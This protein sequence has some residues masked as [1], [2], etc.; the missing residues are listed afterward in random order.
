MLRKM[1][2]PKILKFLLG[3]G[4]AA[5]LNLVLIYLII[6][7]LG[8]NTA[9]LR[10]I[11]NVVSIELSLIFSFFVYRTWVWTGGIWNLREV[12]L[13][14]LPL[15]HVSAGAAVITRIFLIFPILDW[16]KVNYGIN[17]IIGAL[18]SASIN[19][20]ISDRFVFK[21]PKQKKSLTYY[22]EALAPA[23][24]ENSSLIGNEARAMETLKSIK[25]LSIVIPAYNEEDCI[26]QTVR[27][28]STVLEQ[29]TIDYEIL[30]VNDNSK[31]NTEQ[32]LQQ[33]NS[34]NSKL[35]YINNYYPNGFGF[36]VRCGLE[37]FTKDAVAVVM[38]DSSDAPE[39]I[40][41]YYHKLQEGYDCVFG[42][43]FIR[44]GKVIDYPTHKLI[45]N[46]LA[47]LFI[48]ILFGL[49]FNDTTNAFKIYRK[50]VIEGISP[51]VSHHFNLTVEMP[52]KAIV[53]GYSYTTIP[54]TW[55]N[56]TTGV[57]KL[58]LKE[59]GSRYLFIVLFIWLE[60]H[61][62]RGDYHLSKNKLLANQRLKSNG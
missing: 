43:R 16:L 26:V 35:R 29:E 41:S 54:I 18:V 34:E 60:K 19:Y 13:R 12:F 31:D 56:R 46:R 22:P 38:A 40:I 9:F 61:L 49:K 14:Q 53:R 39:D 20:L 3:G 10:N 23:L 17:T 5:A 51:L 1:L 2:K 28:I 52:L 55:R 47:N 48:K 62:S 4:L 32:L 45:V 6:E 24:L 42:S 50:E 57:S 33:L 7:K 30:V 58:K 11:A 25:T 27:T 36:A 37:N 44:G 8:F 21:T 15:Y 59:M